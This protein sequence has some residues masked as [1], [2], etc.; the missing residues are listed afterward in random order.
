MVVLVR[1]RLATVL[2]MAATLVL[3]LIVLSVVRLLL[4]LRLLLPVVGVVVWVVWWGV[5]L[6]VATAG[7]DDVAAY[8]PCPALVH[9]SCRRDGEALRRL[10]GHS[11]DTKTKAGCGGMEGKS[12]GCCTLSFCL[13]ARSCELAGCLGCCWL[14]FRRKELRTAWGV[15]KASALLRYTV[16]VSCFK[17]QDS[18][19]S[20]APK[21]VLK[22]VTTFANFDVFSLLRR[23]RQKRN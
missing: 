21:S 19:L 11:I 1:R 15:H 9:Q 4:L 7:A 20:E 14:F 17:P 8:D 2:V 16:T 13:C 10:S 6:G 22:L 23:G 18:S 12:S 5:T 3:L